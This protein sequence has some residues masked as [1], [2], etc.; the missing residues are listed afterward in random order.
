MLV[1]PSFDLNEHFAASSLHHVAQERPGCSTE[2]NQ[3]HPSC[4][5]F[6]R[7]SN[8]FVY[9]VQRL[10]NVHLPLE[11][12]LV[13]L[14]FGRLQRVGK[15]GALLVYHDDLHTHGLWDDEDIGEDNGGVDEAS[16]PFDGLQ[17]ER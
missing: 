9:I 1:Y 12:F 6:P 10:G 11:D 14:V 17:R 4:Q 5:L 15:V 2:A 7:Q 8:C 13:L 16:I 3:R